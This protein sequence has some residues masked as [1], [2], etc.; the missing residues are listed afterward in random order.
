MRNLIIMIIRCCFFFTVLNFLAYI[1][2]YIII[3]FTLFYFD[4][5]VVVYAQVLLLLSIDFFV[6]IFNLFF[7]V[8]RKRVVVNGRLSQQYCCNFC[9]DDVQNVIVQWGCYFRR[10]SFS[11]LKEKILFKNFWYSF[12]LFKSLRLQVVFFRM[13]HYL[14]RYRFVL[15]EMLQIV[16]KF[17]LVSN[18]VIQKIFEIYCMRFQFWIVS[19]LRNLALLG[20]SGQKGVVQ[21][22]LLICTN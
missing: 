10:K 17:K 13:V 8:R 12:F 11:Y 14:K 16:P 18:F 21:F 19:L 22:L 1:H 2:I 15:Q 5:R 6:Y 20:L 3:A 9:Q 7:Y 4:L